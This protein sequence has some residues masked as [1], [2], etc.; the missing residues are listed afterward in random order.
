LSR[1]NPK[2][3]TKQRT[4]QTWKP[5]QYQRRSLL[6]TLVLCARGLLVLSHYIGKP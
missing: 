6:F 4:P 3:Q 1:K 5:W 2:K